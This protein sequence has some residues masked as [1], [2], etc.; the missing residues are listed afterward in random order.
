MDVRDS[1]D[2]PGALSERRR[3]ARARLQP[4]PLHFEQRGDRL[5]VVAHAMVHF[6]EQRRLNTQRVT[7]G[8]E[9]ARVFDRD[10]RVV[11]EGRE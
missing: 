10:R 9:E 2:P 3:A 7:H 6:L 8:L 4:P 1:L 11:G 5:E